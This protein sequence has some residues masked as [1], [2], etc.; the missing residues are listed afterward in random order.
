MD[1]LSII[2]H[3]PLD[4][5]QAD[6]K[7]KTAGKKIALSFIREGKGK[8]ALDI[9]CRDGYWSEVLKK[10]GYIVKS[11]DIE[12]HYKGALKHD[13]EKGLPF[14][15]KTFDLIWCTEVLEH[16]KNPEFLIKEIGRVMKKNGVAILTTPNSNWWAYWL[17]KLWGWTPKKL[18]NKDHKQF[19]DENTLRNITSGYDIFGYFPYALI[20][21]KIKFFLGILSPTFILRKNFK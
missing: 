1:I 12:P 5:G 18:Q 19:F 21:L 11:L 7:H 4:I 6:R 10:K 8:L 14:E 17:V 13:V 2:Q 20:F 15:N 3:L 9:G 16:L